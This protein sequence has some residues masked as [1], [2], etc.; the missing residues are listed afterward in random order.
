MSSLR[1][2]TNRVPPAFTLIETLAATALAA[3]VM[4]A[5]LAVLTRFARCGRPSDGAD[6]ARN[7]EEALVSV[8]EADLLNAE[9]F[10]P[11]AGGFVLRGF[12]RLDDRTNAI[13]HAAVTVAYEV[14]RTD[15]HSWLLRRQSGPAAGPTDSIRSD[16]LCRGVEELT[17]TA[18]AADKATAPPSLAVGP[19]P[20]PAAV[21]LEIR[22]GPTGTVQE[23]RLLKRIICLKGLPSQ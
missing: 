2:K 22:F 8:I 3:T 18:A 12:G 21:Q 20:V 4:V 16:L 14:A 7:A 11:T 6:A 19:Q 10:E 5:A 9:T 23:G 17:L 15:R 13:S 1:Y